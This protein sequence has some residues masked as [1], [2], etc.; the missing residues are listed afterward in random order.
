M[1]RLP[2]TTND[3]RD[4]CA[5]FGDAPLAH[6]LPV[7]DL[8]KMCQRIDDLEAAVALVERRAVLAAEAHGAAFERAWRAEAH[9]DDLEGQ[10][11]WLEARIN[12]AWEILDS[13]PAR[14]WG[15][16]VAVLKRALRPP[17]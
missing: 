12:N 2:F 11:A 8:L 10:V 7:K 5:H 14:G 1:K 15:E 16:R 4:Q 13:F 6:P 9:R 17:P 3:V